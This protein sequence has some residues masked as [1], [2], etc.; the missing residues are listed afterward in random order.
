MKKFNEFELI[1]IGVALLLICIIFSL[2]GKYIF[3]LNG[4]YLTAA[5]TLF[6]AVV[7]LLLFNDWRDEYQIKKLEDFH[8]KI[9][10]V[11]NNLSQ[12]YTP[13]DELTLAGRMVIS[14]GNEYTASNIEENLVDEDLEKLIESIFFELKNLNKLLTEYCVYLIHLK[15]K[16]ADSQIEKV[17]NFRQQVSNIINTHGRVKG[18]VSQKYIIEYVC[19]CLIKQHNL[20]N[21]VFDLNFFS[22]ENQT[23]FFYT[24]FNK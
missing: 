4:D 12:K 3:D 9:E 20:R 14:L 8:Q 21:L 18:V 17:L 7:V 5:A 16:R 22:Y 19:N 23:S 10:F 24:I 13:L 1:G 15:N 11:T 2:L 6:T